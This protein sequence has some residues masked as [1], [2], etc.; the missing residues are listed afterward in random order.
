MAAWDSRSGRR[1]AVGCSVVTGHP[2]QAAGIAALRRA[3]S[4]LG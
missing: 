2:V 1:R 4:L 3:V